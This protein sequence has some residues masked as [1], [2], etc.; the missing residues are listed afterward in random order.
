M[1]PTRRSWSPALLLGLILGPGLSSAGWAQVSPPPGTAPV[2]DALQHY[3]L[4]VAKM[5]NDSIAAMYTADGELAG[6]GQ[7]PVVGPAAIQ[8]FL[9][10]FAAYRVLTERMTSD[11]ITVQGDTAFQSGRWWQQVIIPAGDTVAVHG[12]FSAQW[13]RDSAGEWH[14]RRMAAR[15]GDGATE[16]AN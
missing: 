15:P 9:Q 6:P 16:R 10:S 5:A 11:S 13:L 12:G 3:S 8:A 7:P 1:T 14:L 4:L 2:E